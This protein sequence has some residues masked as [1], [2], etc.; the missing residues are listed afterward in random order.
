M[1][2]LLRNLTVTFWNGGP[3]E[4]AVSINDPIGATFS[5]K[6]YD[7]RLHNGINEVP[8]LTG[9]DVP[10][11]PPGH[12][13]YVIYPQAAREVMKLQDEIGW[14]P[15]DAIMCKQLCPWIRCYKPINKVLRTTQ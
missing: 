13:A 12:S 9:N 7:S 11:G 15:N 1:L 5:A 14:W 4:G 6:E 3:G 2:F 8:W 10:Q